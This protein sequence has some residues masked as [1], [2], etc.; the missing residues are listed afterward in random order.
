MPNTQAEYTAIKPC[1]GYILVQPLD[2]QHSTVFSV[3]QAEDTPRLAK[4]L[5]VGNKTYHMSGAEYLAPCAIGNTIIHSGF[6]FEQIKHEGKDYRLVPF[7]KILAVI[8]KK[9]EKI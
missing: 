6:G 4:V 3:A 8:E 1:K 5:S 9:N 7:D 2:L